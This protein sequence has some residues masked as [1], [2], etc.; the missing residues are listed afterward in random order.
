MANANSREMF[1]AIVVGAG[2]GGG[3]AAKTLAVAGIKTL[4]LERGEW[5]KG[6]VYGED[7]LSSQRS[8]WLTQGPGPFGA[9]T[10]K[11]H[12]HDNGRFGVVVPWNAACVGSGTVT[13]GAMA[14]RF[15]E[16]DFKLKTHYGE[17]P[18][19]SIEDWPITYNDLEPYYDQA[20]YEIGVAGS[21]E[22]NPFAAPRKRPFPMPPFPLNEESKRVWEAGKKLGLHP[23][24]APFLR[25]S[26]PYNGRPACIHQRSCVGYRC[27]IDAKCGTQ[28][29]VIPVALASGNCEL[30]IRA[31]VTGLRVDV[32]G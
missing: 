32:A 7:D 21:N 25:N 14:W 23:F 2:A 20:E 17:L 5:A 8:P 1:D 30:R 4:L 9:R 10:L 6:D 16:T 19:S 13:Y 18:D 11:S 15:L 27:P 26:V 3:C 22:G 29:T 28:N 31:M 12:F 24:H